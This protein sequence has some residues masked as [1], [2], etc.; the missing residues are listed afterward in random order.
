MR[1]PDGLEAAA[2][3]FAA[4][5]A[6]L[7]ID[8]AYQDFATEL[9]TLPGRYAPPAGELLLARDPAGTPLGCA[10][11][12]PLERGC[13]ELKR[14]YVVP[15]A[16][17]LGLGRA[18]LD[19]MLATATRIGHHEIKLDTLPDMTAALA[20]Y[21]QAGFAPIE[22]YYGTALPG[23]RFLGRDLPG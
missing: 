15:A 2:R 4:Y 21:L 14:L 6:S 12:R 17:G 3:L 16:R 5:A 8:L 9:A 20:L 7:G 19:A 13:C 23:T 11:L 22:P 18:L 1:G 10:A